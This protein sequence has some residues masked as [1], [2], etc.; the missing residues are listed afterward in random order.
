MQV[1]LSDFTDW[2]FL[3]LENLVSPQ[4]LSGIV[5][6]CLGVA[7]EEVNLAEFH[8]RHSYRSFNYGRLI[9]TGLGG[10]IDRRRGAGKPL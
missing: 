10:E 9:L 6:S 5:E 4:G 1:Y 8:V 7:D 2:C 3:W